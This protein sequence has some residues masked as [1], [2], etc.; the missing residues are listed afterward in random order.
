MALSGC[1]T[2]PP[3]PVAVQAPA[4]VAEAQKQAALAPPAAKS[5]KRK[6]A[7]GRFTNETRYGKALLGGD[8]DPLGRQ[9]GDMLS[10]RLVESGRFIV[11]ERPDLAAV[12]AEQALSGG[13]NTVGA[14]T[15]IVGSLTEFGRG[16]EGQAGFLSNTKRQVARAKVEVRLVDVRTGHAY[17]SATGAGEAAVEQGTVMG[18]GSRADY[19]ATLNDRAIGAAI[20]DLLSSLVAK[21]E[22]RPWRSDILKVDGPRVYISGGTRQGLKPGDRLAVMRSGERVKSAQS[23]FDLEL[24][25]SPVAELV[26]ESTFGDSVTSEGSVARIAAGTIPGGNTSGLFVAEVK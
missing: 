22:E 17:F 6:V 23:G 12:K 16:A 14:D 19:D 3:P 18:F 4:A 13:G 15:L 11:L 20:S 1:A 24:P 25:P 10:S 5:F 8:L 2:P 26:V 7:L 21:L 9:T